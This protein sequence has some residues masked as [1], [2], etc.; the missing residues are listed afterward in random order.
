MHKL[1]HL[2]ISVVLALS[3]SLAGSWSY[4]SARPLGGIAPTLGAADSFAILAGSGISDIP[5]S[6]I[7]GN[8]G[9]S[10]APGTAYTGL[11]SAEVGGTIYATDVT[12]PDGVTG[13]NPGLL[14]NAQAANVAAFGAL[15]AGPNSACTSL[16]VGNFDLAGSSL[17][18][19]V[20]CAGTFTLTGTLTL[21]GSGVW[22]F[23]SGSTLIT[24][25]TANVVGGNACSV[26]WRVPSA[27]TLGTNTQLT[28]NILAVSG[29]QLQTGATLN[30]R[31]LV[32]TPGAV[33]LDQ[34]TITRGPRCSVPPPAVTSAPAATGTAG[35]PTTG[36]PGT[37]A[38]LLP[39]PG[40]PKSGG[41]PIRNQD[42]TWS[43]VIVGALSATALV[44]GIRAYRRAYR[45]KQ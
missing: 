43:L 25:L 37:S 24:S 33:T 16:A 17:V 7:T 19:G 35:L 31:A 23:Q 5:V 38:T 36:T 22:I 41:A 34:N 20:Y 4:V 10:P 27:A 18:P 8:V 39:V 15:I 14:T 6:S 3:L 30:G 9:L 45:L 13:N 26:W 11:T 12:G 32:Q 28:G 44:L 42:F 2:T 29:I 40:V 21:A 1:K